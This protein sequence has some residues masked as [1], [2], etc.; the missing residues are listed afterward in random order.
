MNSEKKFKRHVLQAVM[1]YKE[2]LD[3]HC[4]NGDP[5]EK[6][7]AQF[8]VSRN[9]LQKGF[10]QLYG[11]NIREYKLRKRMERS[12]MLLDAGNDVKEVAKYLNYTE[13]RAFSSAFKRF[14]GYTPT[15]MHGFMG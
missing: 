2:L 13:T 11:E 6:L 1:A 15:N 9:V 3:I 14:Y 12:R 4:C 10:K 8:G 5:A 7:S